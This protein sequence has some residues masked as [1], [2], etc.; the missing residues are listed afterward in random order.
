M[1]LIRLALLLLILGGVTL[2]ALQ[3]WSP[4]LPLVILGTQTQ[5]LPL[6]AWMVGSIAL[7]AVTTLAIAVLFRVSNAWAVRSRRPPAK[8]PA[9]PSNSPQPP[10]D[11]E[12]NQPRTDEP[13]DVP[14]TVTNPGYDRSYPAYSDP[15]STA[16]SPDDDWEQSRSAAWDDWEEPVAPPPPAQPRP[17]TAVRPDTRTVLQDEP[18]DF[19]PEDDFPSEDNRPEADDREEWEDWEEWEEDEEEDETAP[20]EPARPIY[21]VQQEPKTRYKS[22]SVYSYSYRDRDSGIGRSDKIRD[23][24]PRDP[25]PRVIVPP[26]QPEPKPDRVEPAP[27]DAEDWDFEDEPEADRGKHSAEDW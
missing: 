13:M 12:W 1:S 27:P 26:Y 18:N 20:A 10:R 22:G 14:F 11:P 15:Y 5:A 9:R 21:E 8:R 16:V 19:R 25:E 4:V 7:G 3:N 23:S 2:F 6:A 24:A 17:A